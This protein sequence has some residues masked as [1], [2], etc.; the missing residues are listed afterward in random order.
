MGSTQLLCGG[1]IGCWTDK[2]PQTY[3]CTSVAEKCLGPPRR[4]LWRK[5]AHVWIDTDS[6]RGIKEI[7]YFTSRKVAM[8]QEG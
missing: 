4:H 8:R 6:I 2:W 7:R 5:A 1:S 3:S